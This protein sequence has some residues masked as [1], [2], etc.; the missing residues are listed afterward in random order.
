MRSLYTDATIASI[1]NENKRLIDKEISL[2]SENIEL[3]EKLA[4][5]E[6]KRA[7]VPTFDSTKL[8]VTAVILLSAFYS[9]IF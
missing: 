8:N 4:S 1:I 5:H 2:M 7:C 3:R 6:G 9:I